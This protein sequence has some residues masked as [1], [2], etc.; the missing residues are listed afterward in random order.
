M[1]G[2]FVT[3]A[4]VLLVVAIILFGGEGLFTRRE[5]VIM[6]FSGSVDGLNVGAQ[7]NVRGV[8]IGTVTAINIEFNTTTGELRIPV[9]AEIDAESIDQVRRLQVE[10]PLKS[11]VEQLGLRAQLKIQSILT[12]Q[13]FIQLDYHP[14]TEIHYFGDG[15]LIEIPTIPMP[16]EQFDKALQD[17]SI[18]HM[19]VNISSSLSA[20]N[21]LVNSPDTMESITAVKNAFVSVDRLSHE[22]NEKFIPLADSTMTD[23]K[24]SLAELKLILG[25]VKKLTASDSPQLIKLN[26]ALDEIANAAKL[27]SNLETMPQMQK[28]DIALTEISGAAK[29][30]RTIKD[31]PELYNLNIALEEITDAA[32]ALQQ[33]ADTIEKQPEVLLKGKNLRE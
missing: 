30:I 8:E 13:L 15:K 10:D 3:G 1:L 23:L 28:L 29:T 26:T 31:S 24:D 20:I 33:L 27:I 16:F 18:E 19:V 2:A 5:R 9:I 25:E 22:I 12:S 21:R 4:I 17:I 7:V 6:Y 11:I 14:E 32:R